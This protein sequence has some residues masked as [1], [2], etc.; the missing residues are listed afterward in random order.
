MIHSL[1][2]KY[3]KARQSQ[4]DLKRITHKTQVAQLH[5]LDQ[6]IHL[7]DG[8]IKDLESLTFPNTTEC[9]KSSVVTS[10]YLMDIDNEAHIVIAED[11]GDAIYKAQ[12]T[13]A[14]DYSMVYSK[15]LPIL[16]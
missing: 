1:I 13:E 7:F 4:I 16:H 2:E 9:V 10:A 15:S 14:N 3:K 6:N 12:Q 11:I 5:L 8:F